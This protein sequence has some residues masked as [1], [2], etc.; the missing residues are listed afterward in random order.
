MG[1]YEFQGVKPQIGP[2][3][4]VHPDATLIGNIV[5]GKNCFI[6]PGA[7]MRGDWGRIIIGDDC[8]IQDNCVIH[9]KPG[10][11]AI[12]GNRCHIGHS[13]IIHGAILE[14]QV[15]VGMACIV[16][17]DSVLH[18]ACALAAGTLVLAN[19]DIPEDMLA[20]GAPVKKLQPVSEKL[21][22]GLEWGRNQYIALPAQ[23][24]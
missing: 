23:Y 5:I 17:D 9:V 16:M 2:G 12:L 10:K 11:N 4:Y 6:G 15:F 1:L 3:S 14:D 24:I 21:R 18:R 8:N 19:T 7:R 13:A 22:D 20:M